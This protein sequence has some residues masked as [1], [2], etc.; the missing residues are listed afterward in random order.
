[1]H[2]GEFTL[3]PQHGQLKYEIPRGMMG[4]IKIIRRLIRSF[5]L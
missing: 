2:S 3:L 1:M 4:N 5:E